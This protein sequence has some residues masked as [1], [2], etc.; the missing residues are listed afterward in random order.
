[1]KIHKPII[2]IGLLLL[3]AAAAWAQNFTVTFCDGPVSM[4]QGSGWR[5]V[6]IGDSLARS[7]VVKLDK[8]G[9]LEVTLGSA[10]ITL[11]ETGIYTLAELA[12]T[13]KQAKS[14]QFLHT[15]DDRIKNIVEGN[16]YHHTSAAG[17]RGFEQGARGGDF[18][19]VEWATDDGG[20]DT[21]AQEIDPITQ[22]QNLLAQKQFDKAIAHFQKMLIEWKYPEAKPFFTYYLAYAY[23]EKGQN[24][25]ALK[26]LDSMTV[27]NGH[28]LYADY[29]LLRGRLLLESFAYKSALE[30]FEQYLAHNAEGENTQAVLLL[31][32]YCQKGLGA[33]AMQKEFLVKA[34]DID[35]DSPLGKE[36]A[37]LIEDL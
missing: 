26:L 9:M 10:T 15:V 34:R 23:A 30:L 7:S 11:Y 31:A 18:D 33:A 37:K 4:K 25:R 12:V 28:I 20:N 1:M 22:G 29:V 24:A 35:P 2:I 14:R 19:E 5:V 21:G 16:N 13:A 8:G 3:S 36:A 27:T 6:A 32:S 17:L